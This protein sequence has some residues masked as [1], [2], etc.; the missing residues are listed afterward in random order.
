MA[1]SA[2]HSFGAASVTQQEARIA[3]GP[4]LRWLKTY[5][6]QRIYVAGMMKSSNILSDIFLKAKAD[7]R[8]VVLPEG[9]DARVIE[10]AVRLKTEGLAQPI[11]LGPP[12]EIEEAARAAGISVDNIVSIEPK[13]SDKLAAYVELYREKRPDVTEAIAVRLVR[14]PLF[15]GALMVA[16]GEA[17]GMVGGLSHATASVIQAAALAVGYADGIK[18]PSSLFIMVLREPTESGE[19]MLIFADAAVNINPTSEQLADIAIASA[20]TAHTLTGIEPRVAFL[21]C[22]TKGSAAHSDVDKVIRAVELA[23]DAAPDLPIDGE[24]QVDAAIVPRVAALKAPDSP[25]AGRAN[26]LVF[27]DLDAGNVAYKLTQYLGGAQAVGPIMQGFAAP[28]NDVSRGA[29]VDDLVSVA[30]ITVVQA[31]AVRPRPTGNA[32]ETA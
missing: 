20:R 24:L 15:F 9:G 25:V 3:H 1:I 4:C 32:G 23:R 30:A 13:S 11:L 27:P 19:D 17:D 28:V 2:L 18:T 8:P 12:A 6:V 16:S 26:V 14:R 10:A 31:Q 7:P 5:D 21:S 22:S 29:C